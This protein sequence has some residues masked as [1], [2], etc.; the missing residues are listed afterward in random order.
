MQRAP[1][2]V[3]R[4]S[5]HE[6]ITGNLEALTHTLVVRSH[7]TDRSARPCVTE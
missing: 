6:C 2:L 3:M 1:A 7:R 5:R 4:E